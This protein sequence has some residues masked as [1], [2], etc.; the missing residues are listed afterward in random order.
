MMFLVYCSD[1]KSYYIDGSALPELIS[2]MNLVF[3]TH[4]MTTHCRDIT[5]HIFQHLKIAK[6]FVCYA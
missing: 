5:V 1:K 3:H 4:E 2:E 6:H